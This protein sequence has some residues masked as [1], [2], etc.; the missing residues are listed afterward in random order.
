MTRRVRSRNS[1]ERYLEILSFQH[2]VRYT[3]FAT[4]GDGFR[5]KVLKNKMGALVVLDTECVDVF[6]IGSYGLHQDIKETEVIS[7]EGCIQA[8]KEKYPD[9]VIDKCTFI[10]QGQNSYVTVINDE[11]IFKFSRY[12]QVIEELKR[13][14][15]FLQKISSYM[16][17]N[18]PLPFFSSF[19]GNE[20]GNVFIGYK[21]IEG[22][23]LER[24]L[25]YKLENK[26]EVAA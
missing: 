19:E 21:M 2:F 13:E 23:P 18:I 22:V 10:N 16:T 15:I 1:K 24:E 5:N 3:T 14:S 26:H 7:K 9:L 12:K 6:P 25:L 17:L 20:V 8:V 4:D 11:I